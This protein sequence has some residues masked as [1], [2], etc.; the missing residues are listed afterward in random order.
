MTSEIR[1]LTFEHLS[2]VIIAMAVAIALAVPAGI[3]ATRR[4]SWRRAALGFANV[5]QTVPSLALFGFQTLLRFAING[6]GG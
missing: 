3:A 2:L 6:G 5:M 1:E 4:A